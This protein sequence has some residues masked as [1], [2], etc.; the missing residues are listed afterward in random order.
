MERLERLIEAAR[1]QLRLVLRQVYR[2][3]VIIKLWCS[4]DE[5][6]RNST[7][8]SIPKAVTLFSWAWST[9]RGEKSR[10]DQK[11]TVPSKDDVVKYSPVDGENLKVSEWVDFNTAA[12]IRKA[13]SPENRQ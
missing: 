7:G 5:R 3:S 11:R 12:L 2:N 1:D 9:A 13:C 6:S 8:A 10:D 4:A